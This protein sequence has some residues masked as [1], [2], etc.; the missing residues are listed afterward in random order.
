[1]KPLHALIFA[2][3][4]VIAAVVLLARPGSDSAVERA[5]DSLVASREG[6]APAPAAGAS[7]APVELA[8]PELGSAEPMLDEI[9]PEAPLATTPEFAD[10]VPA[11][12]PLPPEAMGDAVE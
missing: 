9:P 10:D 4:V 7:A 5:A 8:E 6:A 2:G 1:M 3:A 11:M 12:E